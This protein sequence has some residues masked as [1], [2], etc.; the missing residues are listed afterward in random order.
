M[1]RD[2]NMQRWPIGNAWRAK[3]SQALARYK[4][5]PHSNVDSIKVGVD[6]GPSATMINR[7]YSTG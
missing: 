2:L 1:V 5:L 7:D 6:A 3:R 4:A